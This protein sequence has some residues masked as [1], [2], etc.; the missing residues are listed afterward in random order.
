MG[1]EHIVLKN[2]LTLGQHE[3]QGNAL[4]TFLSLR[5]VSDFSLFCYSVKCRNSDSLNKV[6][7]VYFSL[8]NKQ[9]GPAGI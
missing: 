1:F 7:E 5:S 4:K 6:S 8:E 2:G 3:F 9:G